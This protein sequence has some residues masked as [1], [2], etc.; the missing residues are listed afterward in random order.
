[1]LCIGLGTTS[2][3]TLKRQYWMPYSP[4][5]C[6]AVTDETVWLGGDF[7][8]VG[9][10]TGCLVAVDPQTAQRMDGL[11]EV[12]GEVRAIISDGGGGYFIGGKFTSVGGLPLKNLAHIFANGLP[13]PAWSPEPDSSVHALGLSGDLLIVGG[14]F[15]KICGREQQRLAGLDRN[16][17][18]IVPLFPSADGRVLAVEAGGDPILIGGDF[19]QVGAASRRCLAAIDAADYAVTDWDPAPDSSVFVLKRRGA[20]VFAG[21]PFSRVGGE[22]RRG[23][24]ALDAAS[25]KASSWKADADGP[26]YAIDFRGDILYA[27]GAF[28]SIGGARR[29]R[30]AALSAVTG[31]TTGWRVDANSTVLALAVSGN[32][33]FVAGKFTVLGNTE[34]LFLGC[35]HCDSSAVASWAPQANREALT[36]L[37]DEASVIAGGF[38]SSINGV[39]RKHVAVLDKF[40]G[41]PKPWNPDADEVVKHF[42]L[43]GDT[44]F[45]SGDFAVIGGR[46]RSGLAA[47][48]AKSGAALD[49]ERK[50]FAPSHGGYTI[51]GNATATSGGALAVSGDVIFAAGREC[52]AFSR[53]DGRRI[54]YWRPYLGSSLKS[55]YALAVSGG[56]L[57]AGGDFSYV[58][59]ESRLW[60]AAFDVTTGALLPWNS[61]LSMLSTGEC[62]MAMAASGEELYIGG[63][64]G[65]GNNNTDLAAIDMETAVQRSWSPVLLSGYDN[66]ASIFSLAAC[67]GAVYAGGYFKKIGGAE[68]GYLAA[69]DAS[70]GR[71][72]PWNPRATGYVQAIAAEPSVV[73]AGGVFSGIMG[74]Y[75]TCFAV[76]EDTTQ[77]LHSGMP[78]PAVPAGIA[79]E[80]IYPNPVIDRASIRFGLSS[81]QKVTIT[82][83]DLLGRGTSAPFESL[84]LPPGRHE[85]S[86]AVSGLRSGMYFL[87]ITG[88]REARSIPFRILK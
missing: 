23:I 25:G 56:K 24:A 29:E 22:E 8:R 65:G 59:G 80:G 50:G 81:E 9:P 16:S 45:A 68:I 10:Y 70:S 75:R 61:P 12:N 44:L 57:F 51:A 26:V 32:S 69:L 78:P 31:D 87:T 1:M 49:W 47:I 21:G 3:Q 48:D 34:R 36:L 41:E 74:E 72:K 83:T 39:E 60:L 11:P 85:L 4:V 14:D 5:R 17:G 84:L 86:I 67:G 35:V 43:A 66:R 30:L 38:L 55:V 6:I 76:L 53:T 40:S 52:A 37:A 7:T 15:L 54:E 18:E 13:D 20:V 33:A 63:R 58:S 71:A 27:G 28:T 62:V 2:A 46:Q 42:A 79:I 88:L 73:Y 77:L 19:S 64:F 82:I